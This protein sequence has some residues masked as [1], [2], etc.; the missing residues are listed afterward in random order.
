M[1]KKKDFSRDILAMDDTQLEKFVRAWVNKKQGYHQ[2]TSFTGPGDKG[3]DVVGFLTPALHEGPWHNYQCKQYGRTLPTEVGIGEI[4]KVLY[5]ASL[6]DFTAPQRFFFVAPRQ[7][8]R[9]LKEL[10]NKPAEFRS[11]VLSEWDKYC[12]TTIIENGDVALTPE[13]KAF[14]QAYDFERVKAITLDEILEDSA[15]RP[16]LYEWF[17]ADPGP[18]P[19]GVA[20]VDVGEEELPYITQLVDAYAEREG[21]SF[22]S[23]DEIKDHGGH[24]P[25]LCMQRE[26]YFDAAAFN[27][28]YRD[29]TSVE[30]TKAL[31]R[32]VFHGVADVHMADHVDTLA[33]VHAVM[34]QAAKLQ[35]SG[36]LGNHA[37][38]PVKQGL[39][40]HFVNDGEM[41]WK[42]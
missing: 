36:V 29:N 25:H 14:I 3:R 28:F 27:R 9:N 1:I 4:G 15:A 41:K 10:I 34:A 13:L 26:R 8:N 39:C 31:N 20:P 19:V 16:V 30:D 2:V 37:R 40:H 12:R 21:C 6:G 7:L 23:H 11:F 42:K 17:G 35:P 18:S 5:Y 22:A 24:W 38:I 32:E 33:R